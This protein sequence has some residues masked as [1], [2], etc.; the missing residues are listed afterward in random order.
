[1]DK[2]FTYLEEYFNEESITFDSVNQHV[3]YFAHIINLAA[4][5]ALGQ[6]K[7]IGL[8]NEEDILVDNNNI[9]MGVIEKVKIY[10][11]INIYKIL[12]LLLLFSYEN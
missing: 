10:C 12:I 9:R 11:L 8:E 4:Q 6:L 7:G 1:M 5:D 2:M 3:R